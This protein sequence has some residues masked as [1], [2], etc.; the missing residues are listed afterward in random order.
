MNAKIRK[1]VAILIV[2]LM[3]LP[4]VPAFAYTKIYTPTPHADSIWLEPSSVTGVPAGG[5]FK[6]ECWANVSAMG[7]TIQAMIT[8]DD[9]ILD[10]I[11]WAH[12]SYPGL[13]PVPLPSDA[14]MDN[15][16]NLTGPA[17]AS[18]TPTL[19][20]DE[21]SNYLTVGAT[22]KGSDYVP[23]HFAGVLFWAEFQVI[24]GPEKYGSIDTDITFDDAETFVLDFDLNDAPTTEP[25]TN[26]FYRW[27]LPPEPWL[28]VQGG[29][30]D[31]HT[32]EFGPDPPTVNGTLF[33]ADI[34]IEDLDADWAMHNATLDLYWNT[35]IINM[36]SIAFDLI[37]GTTMYSY[38]DTGPL[39][40]LSIT[41]KDPT[42]TPFGDVLI[43]TITFNITYQGIS[44]PQYDPDISPLD[45]E[46]EIL[47]DTIEAIP[48]DP[49]VDGE[50]RILPMR[51]LALPYLEVSDA[52]MGPEPCRGE[53]FNVTVSIKNLDAAWYLIGAEFR[54][55][56]DAALIEPVQ[57][58][59]GSF[60]FEYAVLQNGTWPYNWFTSYFESGPPTHV[61][62]GEMI[63]P[64]GSGYWHHPFPEGNGTLATITFKV[65]YQSFGEG[66]MSAPLDIIDDL[67]IGIDDPEGGQNIVEIPMDPPVNGTYEIL[68]NWPGRVLDLYGG[69]L[70]RGYGSHPFPAPYGG[71]GPHNPMDLV[72]PQAEVCLFAEVTY[73]YWPVQ[74]KLVGFEVEYPCSQGILMKRTV[75]TDT[76]GIAMLCFEMP[77]PC[78][79]PESL[80]GVWKVTATVDISDT[81]I[82]DTMEYHY[83]Y[84]VHIWKV[85]TDKFEYNH[86]EEVEIT[87]EYGTHAQQWYPALMSVVLMDDL[88]V[89][90]GMALSPTEVGGAEFCSRTNFT[91]IV[92]I[93]VH[94][95]AFAGIATIHV[96]FFDKDPT[97]GGVAWTPEY[98]PP[99][100]IA[101]QPY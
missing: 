87:V 51:I 62:Y 73:N 64:N 38:D 86:C 98:A 21:G 92:T 91:D 31:A 68:T 52:T 93:H 78:D 5:T 94:K 40:K 97:E 35:T 82:N 54:L 39:D 2:A 77:W 8:W 59:N 13:L 32:W 16:I 55:A 66:N 29:N 33:D 60:L 18:E 10:L 42:G 71:Q 67:A 101:I 22:C 56:Y 80:F 27:Q 19:S 63:L 41:I 61:L 26:Y 96:S 44:P 3:A 81:R 45:I 6:V 89:P 1:L 57:I 79:D 17:E 70:N 48:T 90:V 76:E 11:D 88:I 49:E 36:T 99:P 69:A 75:A 53:E 30:L 20:D 37:W 28:E 83:D 58:Y 50:V 85:T 34:M 100:E 4:A 14:W 23:A 43:A 72:I 65:V 12:A 25:G 46:N 95:S 84:M 47:F 15:R 7:F 74:N 9:T 24:K